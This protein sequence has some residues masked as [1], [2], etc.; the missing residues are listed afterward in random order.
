VERSIGTLRGRSVLVQAQ[1][2]VEAC[3]RCRCNG[4]SGLWGMPLQQRLTLRVEALVLE[5]N[6]IT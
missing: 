4:R 5:K 2:F 1:D 6:V 3:V